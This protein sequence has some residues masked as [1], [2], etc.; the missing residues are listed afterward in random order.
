M[1]ITQSDPNGL[2]FDVTV[3]FG[4]D[5]SQYE[6]N[7][8]SNVTRIEGYL[9]EVKLTGDQVANHRCLNGYEMMVN[10]Y[11]A[12]GALVGSFPRGSI[13]SIVLNDEA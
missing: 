12:D 7:T 13:R 3:Q 4:E 6:M 11:R 9:N 5:D 10:F 2:T 8:I 1:D